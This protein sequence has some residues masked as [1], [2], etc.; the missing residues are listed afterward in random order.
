MLSF[1]QL[2]VLIDPILAL[3]E[4]YSQSVI[5]DI[6]RRLAGMK[7]TSAAAWQMQRLIE[8]GA[9]YD[10][11]LQELAKL[12]GLSEAELR[13]AFKKAGVKA[14]EFDDAVYARAGLKPLPLNLS[15]AMTEVLAAGLQKTAGVMRNLTSTTALAAQETFLDAAD[16][17]YMQVSSGAFDY[18]TAIR[19]AVKD[20]AAKGVTVIGYPGGRRDQV[21]V[22]VRR[23]VLTGINTTVAELQ[24]TRAREMGC[25]LVQVSAHIGSRPSH[26]EFQGKIFRLR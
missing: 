14:I 3:Y 10:H 24:L 23:C 15:P 21:E 18:I 17:A 1:D 8:S 12:T 2:D 11:A 13:R 20:V 6:A 22:A 25:I 7:L 19:Q 16:L 26:A 5:T 4:R 9:V